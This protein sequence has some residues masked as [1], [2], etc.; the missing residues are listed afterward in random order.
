[1]KRSILLPRIMSM[2][3]LVIA[4]LITGPLAVG[5]EPK[6]QAKSPPYRMQLDVETLLTEQNALFDVEDPIWQITP[7]VGMLVL[8]L[9]VKIEP[10]ME[11]ADLFTPSVSI[12]GGR[13]LTWRVV[14]SERR[15]RGGRGI[16][17]L[18]D[19]YGLGP[20]GRKTTRRPPP[21]KIEQEEGVPADAPH[22]AR[23][24]QL[25]PDGTIHWRIERNIPNGELQS[26][27]SL[28]HYKLDSKL[29]RNEN[30]AVANRDRDKYNRRPRARPGGASELL[31]KQTLARKGRNR[32]NPDIEKRRRERQRKQEG[33]IRYRQLKQEVQELPEQFTLKEWK[34]LWLVFE[35]RENSREIVVAD[36]DAA[37]FTSFDQIETLRQLVAGRGS[38]ALHRDG[39]DRIDAA[40]VQ[41]LT[42]LSAGRGALDLRVA[43][44][45]IA[46]SGLIQYMQVN[47]PVFGAIEKIIDGTDDQ[48]RRV[49]ID[50]VSTTAPQTRATLALM[51]K[52][53]PHMDAR[54]KLLSLQ[55]MFGDK[56][57]PVNPTSIRQAITIAN[58]AL[59]DPDGPTPAKV[60]EGV[61]AAIATLE[62][63]YQHQFVTGLRFESLNGQRRDL[64]IAAVIETAGIEPLAANWLNTK[65]LGAADLETVRQTLVM[66]GKSQGNST[67]FKSQLTVLLDGVFGPSVE[68]VTEQ[69]IQGNGVPVLIDSH[70][71]SL[72][73][74]L[75]HG[76]PQIRSLAWNALG[77]F[78]LSPQRLSQL[79][80]QAYASGLT[81]QP[82][83]R[84][85]SGAQAWTENVDRMPLGVPHR[86]RRG[87][88]DA[89]PGNPYQ[90]LV[91]AA[92]AN[93]PIPVQVASFLANEGTLNSVTE[94]LVQIVAGSDDAAGTRAVVAL[95]DPERHLS[96]S[97]NGME[98]KDRV[99]FGANIYKHN[100]QPTLVVGLLADPGR[101]ASRTLRWFTEEFSTTGPPPPSRW[102]ENYKDEALYSL[103]AWTDKDVALGAAA[104][105]VASVG[106]DDEDARKLHAKVPAKDNR[107]ASSSDVASIWTKMRREILNTKLGEAAGTY[108]LT[109]HV[110]G[111]AI[112]GT[113]QDAAFDRPGGPGIDGIRAQRRG[114]DN[115]ELP[116]EPQVTGPPTQ[117]IDLG[118][119]KFE[120][121]EESIGFTGVPL[122]IRPS[123]WHFAIVIETPGELSMLTKEPIDLPLDQVNGHFVLLRLPDKSWYGWIELPDS[124][125]VKLTMQ[126]SG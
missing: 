6:E 88:R 98:L 63:K 110:Y 108:H 85:G 44:A 92:L 19:K 106:G 7:K 122:S 79:R 13:F 113:N 2:K 34:Q 90:A 21:Q 12:R 99:A 41:D 37:W 116:E 53:T 56:D 96:Q 72:F 29:L 4:T 82:N 60:V 71:H 95:R 103:V 18:D 70:S 8:Q 105:L 1:M 33:K 42:Q 118:Q 17:P 39:N 45:A 97:L 64:A 52:A 26:G 117:H 30:P 51:T 104:A 27:N 23:R 87:R 81:R 48:A 3:I 40:A 124:R 75:R 86:R 9:P 78:T 73:R 46:T 115:R 49:I 76:D 61:V 35:V 62:D 74:L 91:D 94:A 15:G 119:V 89:A 43:A 20:L 25:D 14:E 24:L 57:E 100:G 54:Q 84:R 55:G 77:A 80:Q 109:L 66:L 31:D 47:G 114:Q 102:R 59:L 123:T 121:A 68:Q 16:G 65:L 5:D 58:E 22:L 36:A 28:Y 112:A 32:T 125:F 111:H 50:A 11:T 67:Q 38:A 101:R 83:R 107:R 10:G 93:D 120:T 126:P 69:S